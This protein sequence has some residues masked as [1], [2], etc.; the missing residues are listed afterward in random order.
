MRLLIDTNIVLDYLAGREPFYKSA[1]TIFDFCAQ[2]K[3]DGCIAPHSF[4]NIFYILRGVF[5]VEE[6]KVLLLDLCKLFAVEGIDQSMVEYVLKNEQF[7]DFEDALQ[8]ECAKAFGADYIITRDAAYFETSS[9]PA[10][11]PDGF[12]KII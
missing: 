1:E 2:G 12:I 10:I 7:D 11:S 4:S 6:R 8:E 5:S 3:A 9:I